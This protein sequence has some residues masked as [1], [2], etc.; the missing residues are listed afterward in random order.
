M[1]PFF[2]KKEY[3]NNS[4][5]LLQEATQSNLLSSLKFLGNSAYN[6]GSKILITGDNFTFSPF[7]HPG[8]I[9]EFLEQKNVTISRVIYSK[10]KKIN[11]Y[12]LTGYKFNDIYVEDVKLEN[13]DYILALNSIGNVVLLSPSVLIKNTLPSFEILYPDL[14]LNTNYLQGNNLTELDTLSVITILT[15]YEEKDMRFAF[16]NSAIKKYP[17]NPY[18]YFYFGKYYQEINNIVFAEKMYSLA[19]SKDDSNTPNPYFAQ[20]YFDLTQ[21]H[22]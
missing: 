2:F 19:I 16:L 5:T 1:T 3:K 11:P 6:S 17:D 20:A 21:K 9:L 12:S 22:N 7:V 13:Y 10:K 8:S 15:S 18:F 14:L 4:W